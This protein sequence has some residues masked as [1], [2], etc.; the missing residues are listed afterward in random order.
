[1]LTI[2][3]SRISTNNPEQYVSLNNQINLISQFVK[4]NKIK[5]VV[6]ISERK[7]ISNNISE[8][9]RKICIK[10]LKVNIIVTT[11]D[12]LSRNVSDLD[13]IKKYINKIYVI[14]EKKIYNPIINWKELV[15]S[16]ISSME[17]IEKIRFRIKQNT[18]KR[19]KTEN[20]NILDIKRRCNNIY[21][22]LLEK[23]DEIFLDDLSNFI[24]KSQNIKSTYELNE[25]DTIYYQYS[26]NNLA[27]YYNN[28]NF[29][30]QS[31][32]FTRIDLNEYIN[33]ILKHKNINLKE[34]PLFKEFVNSHIN[35]S[36]KNITDDNSNEIKS[37]ITNFEN[38][39]KNNKINKNN[40]N[41]L[42]KI[43]K[44]NKV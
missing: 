26:K 39:L 11:L 18:N 37:I 7:S 43:I 15:M 23:Y 24:K 42:S 5:N 44:N 38:L 3:Y 35:Y 41:Y 29:D 19:K 30:L 4:S 28:C 14:N 40:L 8:K 32:H 17:E 12:R 9:L 22:I 1:M 13:F 36:R 20:D 27:K 25:L 31:Y 6:N 2:C 21:N 10:Y 16:N 33:N 34:N